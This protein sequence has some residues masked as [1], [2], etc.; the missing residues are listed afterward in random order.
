MLLLLAVGG[1]V[2]R[3][4]TE[5]RSRPSA[6][7][8]PDSALVG[9]THRAD[10]VLRA[11]RAA[12][13]SFDGSAPFP[14][15][16]SVRDGIISRVSIPSRT[17]SIYSLSDP[18]DGK[19]RYIGQTRQP[20]PQ[21][22]E[23]HIND[24]TNPAMGV[25]IGIL[26]GQGLEPK[27]SQ[28][29]RVPVDDLDRVEKE[30]IVLHHRRGHPLLNGEHRRSNLKPL[31][32]SEQMHAGVRPAAV[33]PHDEPSPPE[34]EASIA[35]KD[36]PSN[37]LGLRPDALCWFQRR[38]EQ[39]IRLPADRNRLGV[40]LLDAGWLLGLWLAMTLHFC[41]RG[42]RTRY[43][44]SKALRWAVLLAMYAAIVPFDP[45]LR[46]FVHDYCT[47]RLPIG[48]MQSMWHTYFE[49]FALGALR[50][51]EIMVVIGLGGSFLLF[52]V[53]YSEQIKLARAAKAR[54]A[55]AKRDK[56]K[57]EAAA[58]SRPGGLVADLDAAL[59]YG[60]PGSPKVADMLRSP[61]PS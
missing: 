22:K 55:K 9:P 31:I 16:L 26:V 45:G 57:A 53:T 35:K 8:Q 19:I 6:G 30:Q 37:P 42:M 34:P 32:R 40:F 24:P 29:I 27:I 23:Q 28:V 21:R 41:F 52:A 51:A 13:H 15:Q 43:R 2:V 46:A 3:P 60:V 1:W 58:R 17:G 25:W 11:D 12:S 61:A 59:I 5:R 56:Q 36:D 4:P 44:R 18:R 33:A 48:G 50:V 10:L 20:L 38:A 54:R 39:H 47:S 14:D 49:H 7:G